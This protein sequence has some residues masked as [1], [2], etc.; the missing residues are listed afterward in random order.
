M[1]TSSVI[2]D[3][4]MTLL[5]EAKYRVAWRSNPWK[6]GKSTQL[7]TTKQPMVF[8]IDFKTRSRDPFVKL[9]T[10][11]NL[12]LQ[13]GIDTDLSV[14]E[15]LE[16]VRQNSLSILS[17]WDALPYKTKSHQD[18]EKLIYLLQKSVCCGDWKHVRKLINN[19]R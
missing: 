19:R 12:S 3:E 16:Y 18:D 8:G 10:V 11:S 7:Q 2:E 15:N 1:L 14:S 4:Q 5:L 13:C 17:D 9:P 6:I